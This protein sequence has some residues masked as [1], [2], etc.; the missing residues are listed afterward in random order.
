MNARTL[1]ATWLEE[2]SVQFLQRPGGKLQRHSAHVKETGMLVSKKMKRAH[3]HSTDRCRGNSKWSKLWHAVLETDFICCK[4]WRVRPP[5]K[6][7]RLC[8][9]STEYP[10]SAARGSACSH[11]RH[12]EGIHA[13]GSHG[14]DGF[15][16]IVT[17]GVGRRDSSPDSESQL[18]GTTDL[19]LSRVLSAAA[20]Q[21]HSNRLLQSRHCCP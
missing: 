2:N 14:I 3:A 7:A 21:P 18:S 11:S 15:P 9:E 8:M 12:Q 6:S 19:S 4:E 10:T 5:A 13:F 16:P 20:R 17:V 1:H